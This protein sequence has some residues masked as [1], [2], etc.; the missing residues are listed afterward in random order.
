MTGPAKLRI[1]CEEI[2][3]AIMYNQ[4]HGW[5]ISF[6]IISALTKDEGT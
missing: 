2:H 4:M 1:F 3:K 6:H 5:P